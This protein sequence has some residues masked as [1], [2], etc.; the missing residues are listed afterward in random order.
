GSDDRF[1]DYFV[2]LIDEP[3]IYARALSASE[4]QAIYNA[5]ISGK[6]PTPLAVSIYAQPADQTVTIGQTATFTVGASGTQPISYQW[7]FGMSIIPGATDASLVL[8]KVQRDQ[9][10]IY[11]VTVTNSLGSAISSNATLT[12]NFPPATVQIQNST[13]A[14]DGTVTVPITLL[15]NG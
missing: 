5:A 11:W 2:G 12:V 9:A 8:T 7:N 6:C 15:A 13:A 10:G 14:P 1:E 3:T 4:V